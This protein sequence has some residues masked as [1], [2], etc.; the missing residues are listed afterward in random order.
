ME[1]AVI[2]LSAFGVLLT[3]ICCRICAKNIVANAANATINTAETCTGNGEQK[4]AIAIELVV[5][6]LPAIFRPFIS[7]EHIKQVIQR[8][9]DRVDQFVATQLKKVK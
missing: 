4:M 6:K 2:V 8:V 9:F 5:A 7:K 1:I 3:G